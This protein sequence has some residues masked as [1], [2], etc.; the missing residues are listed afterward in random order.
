VVAESALREGREE[1][2]NS[3]A[4]KGKSR[5]GRNG[6]VRVALQVKGFLEGEEEAI[7]DFFGKLN[8]ML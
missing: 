7:R 1:E 3:R 8:R 4:S 6:A 5:V 2:R